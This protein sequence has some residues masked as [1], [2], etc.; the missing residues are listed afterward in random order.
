MARKFNVSSNELA[1]I[2]S[3]AQ[4]KLDLLSQDSQTFHNLEEERQKLFLQYQ[5]IAEQLSE[6]RKKSALILAKKVEEELQFLKM[7]NVKFLVVVEKNDST[8]YSINGLDKI[9]FLASIN[10]NNFDDI[11]KIA[12]GGELSR[13]MLAL[14]VALMDI[15]SVPTMIFD[16]IDSGIGGGTADAVGK[17][18]K[19][20]SKNL[21]ILVVT[22]QA[23]IAAKAN[24]HFC[25]NKTSD[26][27][28]IKTVIKKLSQDEQNHEIARMI[29]G[30]EITQE[31]L[32]TARILRGN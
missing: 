29:S 16:E 19:I 22:H 24:L 7:T 18:L 12:S 3:D 10:K 5:K 30:E 1:K 8:P 14:K 9:K 31:A 28:K 20:L 4:T 25:I 13:F 6:K 17:R 23:Q 21:Q 26:K 11:T 2:I 27:N 15:K 32:A